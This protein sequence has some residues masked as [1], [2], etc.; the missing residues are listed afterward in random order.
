MFSDRFALMSKTVIALLQFD[1][2]ESIQLLG[3]TH[4]QK[5]ETSADKDIYYSPIILHGF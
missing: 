3:D 5:D 1:I 4:L 2:Q